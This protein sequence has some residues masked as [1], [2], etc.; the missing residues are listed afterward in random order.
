M[1]LTALIRNLGKMTNLGLVAPLSPATEMVVAKLGDAEELRRARVHPFSVLLALTQYKAGQGDKGSLTWT[2][3]PAVVAALDRAF[4]DA[5]AAVEP[6]GKRFVVAMDVSGSMT[7]GG[8][9]GAKA[10]TP[11]VGA[12]AMAMVTMRTE[13]KCHPLAF[14]DR[15]V[16]L[17]ID[18]S[19]SLDQVVRTCDSL[20]FG[21]TDCAQPMLWALENEVEAEVFVVYTDC[22][23]W[24]GSVSPAD[25]LRRYRKATG[26]PARLVVVA[27]TSGGFSL[28]DPSDA[29]MLDVVGFDSAAPEVIR[30]F[31]LGAI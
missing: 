29:G 23:T 24:A 4:Y 19:M 17:A 11:R 9:N 14:T 8:V 5:F 18:A 10:I 31:A 26:I 6:V 15:L 12:A 13:A 2:P 3:V 21:A 16:P 7:W 1:G 25:A 28:A 22:E 30:Q 20:P 27:M